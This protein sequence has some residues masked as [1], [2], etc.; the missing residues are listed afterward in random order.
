MYI[1]LR[2]PEFGDQR[3]DNVPLFAVVADEGA[4]LEDWG[5]SEEDGGGDNEA[6]LK[7]PPL[8]GV[9]SPG[10]GIGLE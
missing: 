4:G 5:N 8:V 6:L 7:V 3:G 10:D 1:P 9:A 2:F